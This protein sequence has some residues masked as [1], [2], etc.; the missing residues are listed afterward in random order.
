MNAYKADCGVTYWIV[1]PNIVAAMRALA[2]CWVAE[3]SEDEAEHVT[4]DEVPT[5]KLAEILVRDD[6]PDTKVPLDAIVAAAKVPAV[7]ACSEW[8]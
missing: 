8:P 5:A 3:G 4:I 2:N 6:G 7:V 1:A